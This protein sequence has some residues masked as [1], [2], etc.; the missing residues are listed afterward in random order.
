MHPLRKMNKCSHC[1][2]VAK[3]K[4]DVER[5]SACHEK[6][7]P[8]P[9]SLCTYRFKHH[10]NLMSHVKK[11]HKLDKLIFHCQKCDFSAIEHEKIKQHMIEIHENFPTVVLS[12]LPEAIGMSPEEM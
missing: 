7:R 5:H 12:K 2:Y 3:K 10:S 8:Y 6:E 9:C 11:F 4:S 1:A